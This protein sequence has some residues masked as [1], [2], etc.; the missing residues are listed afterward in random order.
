MTT[1]VVVVVV[2]GQW[3]VHSFNM[4]LSE[5]WHYKLENPDWI[6]KHLR[7]KQFIHSSTCAFVTM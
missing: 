2:M 6:A 1:V 4:V 5:A 3:G 7:Q